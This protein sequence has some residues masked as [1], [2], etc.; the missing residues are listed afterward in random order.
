MKKLI[1][2]MLIGT[3]LLSL[4]A[5]GASN[6][7]NTRNTKEVNQEVIV[8][9]ASSMTET[10][11]KLGEAYMA[12][13]PDVKIV[14]N[15]DSSG[16]LKTQI[17]EGAE[18]DIFISAGQKQ[19]DQ[20]DITAST[21]IN[22]DGLDFVLKDTRFDILE[23]KVVLAVPSDNPASIQSFDDMIAKLKAG[24][25]MLAVGNLDV[26]VG[27]YTQELFAYYELSKEDPDANGAITY[28]SNVKE[29]TTQVSEEAVDCGIIYQTDAFSAGLTIVD[30]ATKEM[31]GQVVYPAAV[32]NVSKNPKA[33]KA[34][35]EYLSSDVADAVFEE[36]GF[37]PVR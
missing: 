25:I 15:F 35:L 23:N 11:T 34:F 36:V 28:G 1:T 12:G 19:M 7:N 6:A 37:T 13:H 3:L 27:Q 29:V 5:C 10:L 2:L 26:P 8:F 9:A 17:E 18:V 16:T 21:D 31:C 24:S 20:L 30:T 22:T 4:C 32:M 33:A 14:F